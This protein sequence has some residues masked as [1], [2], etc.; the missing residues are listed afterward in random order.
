MCT[1]I[2]IVLVVLLRDEILNW[3]ISASIRQSSRASSQADDQIH[4]GDKVDM[5]ACFRDGWLDGEFSSLAIDRDIHEAIECA[6]YV[7]R[8]DAERLQ[9]LG[10]IAKAPSMRIRILVND[11]KSVF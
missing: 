4:L 2:L 7:I 8:L 9:R 3:L 5:V 1:D 11:A 6:R 10:E